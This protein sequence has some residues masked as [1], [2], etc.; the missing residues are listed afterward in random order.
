MMSHNLREDEYFGTGLLVLR[1]ASPLLFLLV[2]LGLAA[3]QTTDF[4][5]ET[6]TIQIG[7]GP[8]GGYDTQ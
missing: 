2:F 7:Y 1:L 4:K 3:A 8:G 5:G 6:V